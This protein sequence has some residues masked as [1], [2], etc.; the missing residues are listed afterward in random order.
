MGRILL[1]LAP[2]T[3][4]VIH[5][6]FRQS[7]NKYRLGRPQ[8]DAYDEAEQQIARPIRSHPVS[9]EASGI[10]DAEQEAR[11]TGGEE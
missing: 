1:L 8:R 11:R 10:C 3:K 7:G 9:V 2:A 6:S 4:P 5:L